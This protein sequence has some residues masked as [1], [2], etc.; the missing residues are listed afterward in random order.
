MADVYDFSE[1]KPKL[2]VR[3]R[4]QDLD[5]HM[6]EHITLLRKLMGNGELFNLYPEKARELVKS[7]VR[8]YIEMRATKQTVLRFLNGL[9]EGNQP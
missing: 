6:D 7:L 2:E 4:L 9:N 1:L 8:G 5:R 3:R